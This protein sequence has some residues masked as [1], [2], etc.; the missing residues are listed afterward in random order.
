[1]IY[2]IKHNAKN[3]SFSPEKEVEI[4]VILEEM[5]HKQIIRETAHESTEFVSPIFIVKKPDGG[6][7]LIL[8]LKELNEFVKYEHFKMDGIK[9]IINMV[10]R[11]CFMATINLKDAYYSV[12]ISR[13][14]QKFLKFKWKHKLYYFTCFSNGLGSCPRKFTKLNKVPI[15]TLH[16]ENVL[17]S[18]YIDDF[19]TKGD[20]FSICEENIYKTMHLYDKLGFAINFKKSQIV[21][22]Q[23]IRIFGFVIDSVKMIITLT[24]EKKQKLKTLFLNLIR[25]NKPTIRYLAKVIGTII[26]CMPA[27]LLGP[28]FYRYLENDKVTSLRL[29][30]GNFD[31]AAKI[32]PERKQEL[33]W[34][35]KNTDSIE[36]P[37]ALPP[38]DLQYFCDSSSYS[39]GANF[40]TDKIGGAWDIKGKALHINC[41]EL[42]AVYYF[43][44][45]FKTHFQ[46]KRQ[47]IFR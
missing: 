46:N 5:L 39:W 29:N 23:R 3:P 10:T 38:I 15:T 36:K 20:T 9:T 24:E 4:Q 12:A 25:I 47:N 1:M 34:C 26:S 17:L 31:A 2:P 21:L 30:K 22:T 19:F 32:S 37:I 18:G 44:R 40:N 35:L 42:L 27:A 45:S 41:K 8:N 28:L 13:Q 7:R 33:E 16:F 43:L 14:F 11:N 6:T